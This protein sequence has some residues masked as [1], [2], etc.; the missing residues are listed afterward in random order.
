MDEQVLREIMVKAIR[1]SFM[2]SLPVIGSGMIIGLI[3]SIFQAATSIQEQTLTFVPKIIVILI[4][5]VIFGS[6]ISDSMIEF[7]LEIFE[8]IPD[9]SLPVP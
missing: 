2:I 8:L 9:L 6:W 5:L 1:L 4:V 3:I 7:M